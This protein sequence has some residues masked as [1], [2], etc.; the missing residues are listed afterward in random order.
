MADACVLIFAVSSRDSFDEIPSICDQICRAKETEGF[1]GVLVGNKMDL[2]EERQVSTREGE[3]LAAKYGILFFETSAKCNVNIVETFTECVREIRRSEKGFVN[4]AATVASQV[5]VLLLCAQRFDQE[6]AFGKALTKDT[7]QVIAK[8]IF[9]TRHDRAL[10]KPLI[11][12]E[13]KR[14]MQTE[15]KKCLIQ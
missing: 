7:V 5:V 3:D 11:E 2:E 1:V 4:V 9:E 8:M 14:M 12:L 13:R 10:W 6:S 15:K